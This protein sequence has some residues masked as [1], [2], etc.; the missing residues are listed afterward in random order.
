MLNFYRSNAKLDA[1]EAATGKQVYT[2]SLLSGFSCPFA[3]ECLSKAVKLPTGRVTV[4]DGPN[5][6]WR[7]FSAS[8]EAIYPNV[9]KSREDN[10]EQLRRAPLQE[11]IDLI[12]D[13]IPAKAGIVRIHVGGDFFNQEYFDAWLEAAR[14]TPHVIF[15]AYTKSLPYWLA[16]RDAVRK[17]PNFLLTASKGGRLDNLIGKHRL[18]YAK[19]VYT[20]AEAQRL[21]LDIDHDDT[22]VANPALKNQS[23]AL[24]IHGVQPAGSDAG[25]AVRALKGKG[26]YRR[27]K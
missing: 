26:S 1:L 18:R 24:L 12:R 10:F 22:H 16:R 7:C 6:L 15:Y 5:T 4:Q 21:N 3:N 25:K 19:V 13:G 23:F 27:S 17:L 14:L 9:R 20:E 8:E 2:F 11:K